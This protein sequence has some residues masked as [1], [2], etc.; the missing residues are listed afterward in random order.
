MEIRKPRALQM[1]QDGNKLRPKVGYAQFL[2]LNLLD[3]V[4]KGD[5]PPPDLLT[6]TGIL[7][8]HIFNDMIP[9]KLVDVEVKDTGVTQYFLTKLGRT[10]VEEGV[11]SDPPKE[12]RKEF[13]RILSLIQKL[14]P[15]RGRTA[16]ATSNVEGARHV[17]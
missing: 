17:A 9:L 10:V 8:E 13:N 14:R 11:H 16:A 15:R 7:R 6:P 4:A 5:A 12:A 1:V 3:R 2:A